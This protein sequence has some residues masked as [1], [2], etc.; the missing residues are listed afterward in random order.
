M[1]N[2]G[3]CAVRTCE[4]TESLP[5]T[6]SFPTTKNEMEVDG[7]RTRRT[8]KVLNSSIFIFACSNLVS[9]I[10]YQYDNQPKDAKHLQN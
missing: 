1:R 6:M 10:H 7:G 3:L 5:R 9:K 8:R 4:G 2:Y